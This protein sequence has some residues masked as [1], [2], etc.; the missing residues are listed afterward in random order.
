[1]T[2][3]GPRS[4]GAEADKS[5]SKVQANAPNTVL[6]STA[7]RATFRR[8]QISAHDFSPFRAMMDHAGQP[9]E[10]TDAFENAW[11]A[12]V[13]GETGQLAESTITPVASVPTR[14]SCEAYADAG[15]QALG[16][17]AVIRLNGGLGT[18]MGLYR[19]K[20]GLV[21]R[22]GQ[23]FLTTIARQVEA[24]RTTTGAGV[25]LVLMDSFRTRADS[26]PVL[27]AREGFIAGQ[28]PVPVSFVQHQIPKVLAT[29]LSPAP[30]GPWSEDDRWCPPGHGDIYLALHTSGTLKALLAAG[31][32]YAFVANADNLGATP[33]PAILGWMKAHESPFVMEV[34]RRTASDSKG[35]HLAVNSDGRLT[36]REVA[37]CPASDLAYFQDIG[38]HRYFNTNNL[39]VDLAALRTALETHAYRLPLPL[40]RNNKSLVPTDPASPA[41]HQLESAMGAAISVF[42][43]AS[44]IE[45]E[46]SRFLPVKTTGDLLR[47]RSDLYE[48][49]PGGSVNAAGPR[50]PATIPIDLDK[51][52]FGTMAAFEARFPHGAPS[53]RELTALT[54]RG[55]VYFEA[56]VKLVGDVTLE[57]QDG[58][59]RVIAAHSVV[60]GA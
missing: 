20:S 48:D 36:L 35:G 44:A 2:P 19:A 39:W 17:L 56:G 60:T 49:G 28:A 23:S 38:R 43:G 37:Q 1:M 47:L 54:V 27:T 42:P 6:P 40:I 55:D 5:S 26:V 12:L 10:A 50:D 59:T 14:E 58:Q 32:R 15:R 7:G 22:D 21:A 29:D 25:P 31:F 4:I 9:R 51:R 18:S 24:M 3:R 41:V 8:M 34:C 52:F 30:E 45:V 33:D 11:R 16:E 13:R 57:A 46:R 53:L